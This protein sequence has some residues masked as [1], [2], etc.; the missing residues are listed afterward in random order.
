[1]KIKR[2]WI[3]PVLV[4]LALSLLPMQSSSAPTSAAAQEDGLL[5]W[6]D[7][8]RAPA[9]EPIAEQYTTEFG[10]PVRVE[11]VAMG[12]I[13][14]N[15]AVA[16]PAGE[17]PDILIAAHDWIGELVLNGSVIPLNLGPLADQFTEASLNLFTYNGELYGMP[18]AVENIAFFR[19]TDLVPEAPET[20]EEVREI[21][22]GLVGAGQ[23]EY[24]YLIQERDAYHYHPIMTA[25]GGYVFGIGEDGN[26]NPNDV[27]IDSPGN[28]A[29]L[30]WIDSMSE[31]GYL[32]QEIDGD[33]MMTLFESG[34]AAMVMTGPWFLQRI[35][36]SGISYAI[37]N[38]PAGPAGPGQPFIGGQGF[39]ISA[40][41]D[42]QLLAE[43]FLLD[44]M[45][46]F[47][48]MEALYNAD[49]R[50]P[51]YIPLLQAL[52]SED[53]IAF[54]EA[55]VN[56]I[57]QPSIPEMSSVW[58]AWAGS[59]QF[60][61]RGEQQPE[62]AANDAAEIIRALIAGEEV[63]GE[64]AATTSDTGETVS[65][66]GTF[67]EVLGCDS[68]W[69][70]SCEATFLAIGEDDG[71]WDAEFDIPAGEYEYKVAL[72]GEWDENYGV[73]GVRDG[74]NQTLVLEE[75]TT[76]MFVYDPATNWFA[77][78]DNNV[79]ASAPGSY[80]EALGCPGNWLPDCLLSWLQDADGDGIYSF[81]TDLL[82][83][84]DY[85]VK[86]ALNQTWDVNYGVD[87]ERDGPNIS[88]S[89]PED[90]S[91]VTFAFDS[92]TNLLEVTVGE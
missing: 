76:V 13:R 84:G 66:P 73:G 24:G 45:A 79:I 19:N 91:L 92:S 75:D 25:F 60:V 58:G 35:Q 7:G 22:E 80:Q 33:V 70:P 10:I 6:A 43:S 18:Y 29:A 86:V 50:P 5:I 39:M 38:I 74:D 3:I 65:I 71:I 53:L 14:S 56:G 68:N 12:D 69:T 8:T 82:P 87:A 49:P 20:W 90:G 47:E 78:S 48:P 9:L 77:D 54:Q 21:T 26:Y 83:A 23:S 11:E 72:D 16:G 28:I 59:V 52:E 64:E 89:V 37:S 40:F 51:A 44:Y 15:I 30:E 55:G 41:S 63:P 4:L 81:S 42:Q 34:D 62:T 32:D 27:G 17:G 67:Q 61:I 2:F 36:E 85:E 46:S 57:P 88:F 31:E 1:M